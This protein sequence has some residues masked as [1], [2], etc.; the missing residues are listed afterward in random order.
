MLQWY[1]MVWVYFSGS[2]L[3]KF[4]TEIQ[5][6]FEMVWVFLSRSIELNYKS[7]NMVYLQN[8]YS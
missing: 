7:S 4:F 6:L 8:K 3:L 2:I 5:L 1:E